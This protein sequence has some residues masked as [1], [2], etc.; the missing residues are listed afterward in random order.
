MKQEERERQN[1]R[2]NYKGV[3]TLGKAFSLLG[4]QLRDVS[5]L[6]LARGPRREITRQ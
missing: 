6:I 1:T 5:F 4:G 3:A 2:V